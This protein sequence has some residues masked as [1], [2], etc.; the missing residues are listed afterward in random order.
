MHATIQKPIDEILEYFK[1]DERVFVVGCGNCAAKCH[2]GGE[3]ETKEMAE[4]LKQRGISVAGWACTDGGVSLCKLTIT[5]KMLN[6]DHK[7]ETGQTDSY[8][9]LACG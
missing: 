4:R 5:Q 8:L 1:P 7:A 6:E 3:P 2:S 9:I